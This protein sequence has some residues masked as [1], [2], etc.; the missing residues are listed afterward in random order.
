[1]FVALGV[2]VFT[3]IFWVGPALKATVS[4]EYAQ[5][6]LH[7]YQI[8]YPYGLTDDNLAQLR[9]VEGVTDVEAGR[10]STVN[11][12]A[13]DDIYTVKIQTLGSQMDVPT[14]IE[15]SLPTKANEIA[16]KSTFAEQ[17]GLGVGDTMTFVHDADKDSKKGDKEKDPDGMKQLTA[18][19]FKITGL[20]ESAEYVAVSNETYGFT[21]TG[22]GTIHGIAWAPAAAFDSDAFE[23]GYPI[24]NIRS[25]ELEGVDP[26]AYADK[27]SETGLYGRIVELGDD[28]SVA[29]YDELHDKA[30]EQIDD[31]E[32]KVSDGLKKIEDGKKKLDQGREDLAQARIDYKNAIADGEAQ[33]NAAYKKL[34][35]GEAKK[36]K[37]EKKLASARS[38]VRNAESKLKRLDSDK[39]TMRSE[40]ASMKSYRAKQVK[41]LKD[42]KITRA[43][44]N[45][46][47]DKDGAAR[48]KKLKPIV[49][50]YGYKMPT[51]D[52]E[53]YQT[54]I[55][56]CREGSDAVEE[57]EVKVE[58]KTMTV[59]QARHKI[60]QAKSKIADGEAQLSQ[61]SAKLRDGWAQYYA[62]R[63][64][65]E[66]QRVDG[67][68]QLEDAKAELKKAKTK[69]LDSR[70]KI[71]D[72]RPKIAE[73]KKDLEAL[74]KYQWQ[75]DW[76]TDNFG[77]VEVATFSGVTDRLSF[78]MAALFVIV[79]LL[80][81]YSAIGRLVREQIMQ[82]G[83]KKALGLRN[84]EITIS[85]LLY[86][87]LAVVVGAIV[88]YIVAV[89]GVEKIIGDA[90]AA[91]FTFDALPPYFDI[92]VA[93]I[94]LV[95]ELVLVLGAAWLSCRSILKRH[96]VELLKGE[97]PPS[98][99]TRFYEKWGIWEKLPLY[100][101]TMVNNC[102]N[103][104][105]RVF[106]TVVG[107]AGCTALVVTAITLN[108]DVLASYDKHYE[109]TYGFDTIA[110]VDD[111][112]ENSASE[113]A[114]VVEGEGGTTAL[115]LR[116]SQAIE[117]PDG[118]QGAMK[119]V[120]PDDLESFQKLYHINSTSGAEVDLSADG[121]WVS[122][123]YESHAGGKVGDFVMVKGLDG[124]M[125]P[126]Q[127]LGFYDFY[128]TYNEMVMGREAYEKAFETDY[129]PNVV[130]ADKGEAG[131]ETLKSKLKGVDGF[132]EA[133]DDKTGQHGVF[134]DFS[135]VSGAVVL[136]YL[137]L[138]V[139]MAV[140]VLLNLNVM[141]IDEKKRELIVLMINGFSV[142]QAKKY[143]SNDNI[144]LTVL[145]IIC[146][147]I[148]GAIM[149]IITVG[150]IEPITAFFLKVVDGPA[151]LIAVVVSAV[152]SIIMSLIAL[153]RIPAFK[154]TD[155]NKV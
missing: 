101:Q 3:G 126:I 93:I 152:L 70:Q 114:K 144:V 91:R 17:V 83:T 6:S 102:V 129:K 97:E 116:R 140:V 2:G 128:L 110:F 63:D 75:V 80:V 51:I 37:A 48:S 39:A 1:M 85:F 87:A 41:L 10:I 121:A 33:L 134:S 149:G 55:T 18:D 31:A 113:A 89:F 148:V 56:I 77:A 151:L 95:I 131:F 99:K 118:T 53:N 106:S 71:R 35:S 125:R 28:L 127:I 46:R 15:G 30:Q 145:G 24:V 96:A 21:D 50:R 86:A 16:L 147:L 90:L 141:F 100:T 79:G 136:I 69:I 61:Q 11:Y 115:A 137:V 44:Y 108:N 133:I 66:S 49:K 153:R 112:V 58:G 4:D 73:A 34:Q 40:A 26:F 107:I 27:K 9:Q 119:V 62:G 23:G 64:E 60:A 68:K 59:A 150:S 72:A 138:A 88:G 42:G 92:V 57:A 146:G 94:A 20:V 135:D 76:Q 5:A 8:G 111:E 82:I 124:V 32:K 38:K 132:V 13:D 29:R 54:A 117:L 74:K 67:K 81:S 103:D 84:R 36:A 142:K 25:A 104:K 123:A 65:L 120:V 45:A 12:S 22:S 43:K 109:D 130:Y 122:R 78:S 105:K 47:L 155:I 98:G 14:V 139:L 143:I 154:L 52:H 19:A 7:H